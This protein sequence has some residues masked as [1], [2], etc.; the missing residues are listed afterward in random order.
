M[1]SQKTNIHHHTKDVMKFNHNFLKNILLHKN[2]DSKFDLKKNDKNNLKFTKCINDDLV[3]VTS[4]D[5]YNMCD[6]NDERDSP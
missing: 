6:D 2:F 1:Y 5:D 4:S 3:S